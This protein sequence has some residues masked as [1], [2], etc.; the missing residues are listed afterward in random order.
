MN[1]DKSKNSDTAPRARRAR[2]PTR[3]R[4]HG[5]RRLRRH[6]RRLPLPRDGP[7]ICR[8]SRPGGDLGGVWYWNRYPGR[9]GRPAEH[10]LQLFL[11]ARDRAGMDLVGAVRSPAGAAAPTSISS[12]S[13]LGL[14]QHFQFNTRVNRGGLGRGAQAVEACTTDRGETWEATVLRHGDRAAVDSRRTPTS[15][16]SSASGPACC[17][18][19]SGRT[20]RSASR[21]SGSG[22]I[23]TGSTG[24]QIVQEVG[25]QAGELF[26]FQ[27]T[28]SFTMPM[29]NQ[30]LDAGVR[31]RGQ[32]QLPGHPRGRPQQRRR[33][34]AAV[35]RP[36]HSSA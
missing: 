17:M 11:L 5:R 13:K 22:V 31:G 4:P 28:P 35:H 14:R 24:I 33:R 10:R 32:A 34:R 8:P 2:H 18:P 3:R 26:V 20:S 1:T 7:E 12:P 15:P 27:R 19:P 29:R 36:A 21:A 9:A 23:G 16:A 25:P 6:V 30:K